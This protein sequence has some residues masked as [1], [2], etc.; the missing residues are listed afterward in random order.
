MVLVEPDVAE[1]M[2]NLS[3]VEPR[4]YVVRRGTG[5]KIARSMTLEEATA[6]WS[7]GAYPESLGDMMTEAEYR[8]MEW[9]LVEAVDTWLQL[10]GAV[11]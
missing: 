5:N 8:G 11:T 9:E 1:T 3:L 6:I 4:L 2:L 7:R 10:L